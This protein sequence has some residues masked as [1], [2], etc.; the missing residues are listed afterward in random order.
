MVAVLGMGPRAFYFNINIL[1]QFDPH[2]S[3]M[4]VGAGRTFRLQGRS[5][6]SG[7]C[8]SFNDGG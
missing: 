3:D 5:D 8:V 4:R 7:L 2:M 6:L 1:H